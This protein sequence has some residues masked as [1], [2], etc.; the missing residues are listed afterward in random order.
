LLKWQ[1]LARKQSKETMRP[2]ASTTVI[3]EQ[4]PY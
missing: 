2:A 3:V 1:P 4:V